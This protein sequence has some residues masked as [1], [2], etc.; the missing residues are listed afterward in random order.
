MEEQNLPRREREK[1]R[2]RNEMLA[3]ALAL[4]SEKGYHSVSMQEIAEKAEF[5]VG[6]LYKFFKNKEDLYKALIS[7]QAD[8]FHAALTEALTAEGNA[9]ERLRAYVQAKGKIYMDNAAC[10]RLYFAEHRGASF[11]IKAGLDSEIRAR[12]ELMLHRLESVFADGMAT[13]LFRRT[14]EPY[15]LALALDSLCN[16]FLFHWLEE[17]QPYPES[18]DI[19][20]NIFFNGLME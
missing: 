6:T 10:I 20:L 15:H 3:A 11:N 8:R 14:A 1:L 2:Q 4:F 12:C 5:A 16:A 19:L 17:Q 18:P 13:G 7:M 9:V